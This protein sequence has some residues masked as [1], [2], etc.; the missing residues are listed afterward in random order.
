MVENTDE[1]R[2]AYRKKR[3]RAYPFEALGVFAVYGFFRLFPLDIASAL[4]G[5]IGRTVGMRL[6][7]T[8]TILRNLERAMPE[9]SVEDRLKIARGVWDNLGRTMAEYPHLGKFGIEG[10]KSRIEV[11]GAEYVHALATDE[12][13][14]IFVA[15]HLANW[16]LNARI[17]QNL[18]I[19]LAVVSRP[20][21]NPW[22]NWLLRHAR[23]AVASQ[24]LPKGTAGLRDLVRFMRAGGHI[25]LLI[26]QKMND[27]Q[28][29]PFFN[30]PAM[31]GT[32]AATLSQKFACPVVAARIERLGGARFR[33]TFFP[34]LD[35][36]EDPV[37]AMTKINGIIERWIRE[38][39]EQWLWLHQRWEKEKV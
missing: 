37:L 30:R 32:A 4:G 18:G 9:T 1:A 22:V 31:T 15:A 24:E 13:P 10:P 6:K 12:K 26:D 19:P 14:G 36:P 28:P 2:L 5:W 23:R 16:E 7:G 39:P 8:R 34:P 33:M 29:I 21:N 38:R 17:I 11:V 20:P 25:G 3:Q 35:M 27:G